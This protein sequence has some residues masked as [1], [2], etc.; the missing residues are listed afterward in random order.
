MQ[1]IINFID[2]LDHDGVLIEFLIIVKDFMRERL[3]GKSYEK[4]GTSAILI[5][6]IHLKTIKNLS[7]KW[8]FVYSYI[9]K[10]NREKKNVDNY[11][12]KICYLFNFLR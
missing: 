5:D 1:F 2:R 11:V 10:N 8:Y 12:E 6:H 7:V 3:L 4:S 9:Y